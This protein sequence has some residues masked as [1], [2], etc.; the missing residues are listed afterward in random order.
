[1]RVARRLIR[2]HFDWAAGCGAD[3]PGVNWWGKWAIDGGVCRARGAPRGRPGP[4]GSCCCGS[5][6]PNGWIWGREITLVVPARFGSLAGTRGRHDE[7]LLPSGVLVAARK[8][9]FG[10]GG[11]GGGGGEIV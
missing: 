1:M 2:F 10:G 3:G 11:V 4:A 7:P 6:C 8:R 5:G 9:R